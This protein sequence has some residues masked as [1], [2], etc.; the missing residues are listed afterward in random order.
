MLQDLA[1]IGLLPKEED[2]VWRAPGDDIIPTP[3]DRELVFFSA[4]FER[5]L[6][7]TGSK[8]F[9]ELLSYYNLRL[10]DLGPNS[11]L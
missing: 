5:G 8:F 2:G 3:R 10:Q 6:S 4:H 9:C 7:M 11:I 1:K